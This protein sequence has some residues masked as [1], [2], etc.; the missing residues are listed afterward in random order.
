MIGTDS[1]YQE[2]QRLFAKTHTYSAK[3]QVDLDDAGEP[4]EEVRDTLYLLLVEQGDTSELEEYMVK[5]TDTM[6]LIAL[7][8]LGSED[9]WWRIADAN[10]HIRYPLDL[11]MGDVLRIP[12]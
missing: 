3:R 9:Q 4:L 12:E 7:R 1:R 10:P 6:P 11:K 8:F 5:E 2:A